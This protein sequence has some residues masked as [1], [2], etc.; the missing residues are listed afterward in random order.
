ML[1]K[2]PDVFQ[3]APG[4]VTFVASL[5]TEAER[6]AAVDRLLRQWRAD[7]VF[8]AALKGWRNEMYPV[9]LRG[10]VLHA[11]LALQMER[12]GVGI[13]G[14]VSYGVHINGYTRTPDG[15]LRLWI[16]RRSATKQTWPNYL[17]NFVSSFQ[18]LRGDDAGLAR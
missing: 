10:S 7:G 16:A 13:F 6:S 4:G 17:D 3:C 5:Q 9:V 1:E 18:P 11:P 12:A 8:H 2:H 15:Q 14:V